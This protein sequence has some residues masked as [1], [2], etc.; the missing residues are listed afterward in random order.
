VS[1]DRL[2]RHRLGVPERLMQAGRF[3]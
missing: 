3:A 2:L 1:H